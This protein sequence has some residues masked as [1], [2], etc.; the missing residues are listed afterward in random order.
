M[1]DDEQVVVEGQE[2]EA[3]ITS[4]TFFETSLNEINLDK[5]LRFNKKKDHLV[6]IYN[7]SLHCMKVR[8]LSIYGN[9]QLLGVRP[10]KK[11]E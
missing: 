2:E 11:D 7:T 1:F 3:P 10:L 4:M 6:V 9:F 8:F 5:F